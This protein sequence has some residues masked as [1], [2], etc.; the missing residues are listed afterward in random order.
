MKMMNL[1]INSYSCVHV[2]V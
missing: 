1:M 2:Y